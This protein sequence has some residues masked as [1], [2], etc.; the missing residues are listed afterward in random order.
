MEAVLDSG[1]T[2]T[3]GG[4]RYLFVNLSPCYVVVYCA[5]GN[6]MVARWKG[7]MIIS[8]HKKELLIPDSLYI[9]N[10][11]T[12]ISASQLTNQMGLK[13]FLEDSGASIFRNWNDVVHGHP[14]IKSDKKLDD[15]LWYLKIKRVDPANFKNRKGYVNYLSKIIK[16]IDPW[17]L[18]QRYGHVNLP[19]LRHLFPVLKNCEQL[20]ACDGC[21]AQ[22]R[23]NAYKKNY[24]KDSDGQVIHLCY[25][26]EKH[27]VPRFH[28]NQDKVN[29]INDLN[30]SDKFECVNFAPEEEGQRRFGR[31]FS[32]DT[33]FCST[34]SVRGYKYLFV[35]V[36][37][38]TRVCIGFLGVN[39]D[40]F[41]AAMKTWLLNFYNKHG[42]LPSL[43]KF[44]QGGEFLN[45]DILELF[46]KL[47]ITPKYS[48]TAQSN[49]NPHSERKIGVIWTVV[50]KMLSSSGVPMQFWCY[51]A[52]YVIFVL[53]HVPHRAMKFRSPLD[54]AK[55]VRHDD[56]LRVYG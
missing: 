9:P 23:R 30:I 1:A 6:N 53:N 49:Q 15:K 33:K 19:Y 34:E 40:D 18:H 55:F 22:I 35:I 12:L 21:L 28:I 51:C 16:D 3:I 8:N 43:W 54:V 13:V 4:K 39:K 27:V 36:D 38:D 45:H 26:P 14:L 48:T 50:L 2:V 29:T 10:C 7:T 11:V 17:I 42:R 41:F 47:G 25:E 56:L 32:S 5:N 20:K 24:K 31:Y 37:R 44:D 52:M 46:D